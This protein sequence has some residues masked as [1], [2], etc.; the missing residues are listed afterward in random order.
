MEKKKKSRKKEKKLYISGNNK[1]DPFSVKFGDPGISQSI[2]FI[3]K[4]WN[5]EKETYSEF[6]KRI[7]KNDDVKY[8]QDP[9]DGWVYPNDLSNR[10][11]TITV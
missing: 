4:N 7:Y 5:H 8:I 2:D 6:Y 10:S 3:I 9:E 1:S 11:G